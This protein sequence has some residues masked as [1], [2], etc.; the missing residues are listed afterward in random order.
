MLDNQVGEVY[1]ADYLLFLL[2]RAQLFDYVDL[3]R[4]EQPSDDIIFVLTKAAL[5]LNKVVL[6]NDIGTGKAYLEQLI[7]C[8]AQ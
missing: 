1:L 8:R 6:K 2:N 7:G 4:L 3:L 5:A